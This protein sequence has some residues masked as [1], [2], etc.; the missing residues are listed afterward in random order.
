ML[1][2]KIRSKIFHPPLKTEVDDISVANRVFMKEMLRKWVK[3]LKIPLDF[4]RL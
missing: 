1:F 2:T 3:I 4:E